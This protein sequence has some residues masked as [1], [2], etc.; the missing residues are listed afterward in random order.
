VHRL[1]QHTDSAQLNKNLLL[2][3]GA[4]IDTKPELLID[5]DDVKCKHGATV[6]Q[7]SDE[8]I[9]Y[10]Q[11]RAVSREAAT[12]MLIHGFAGD[13]LGEIGHAGIRERLIRI[14]EESFFGMSG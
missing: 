2:S 5:A 13:V 12:R 3:P 4:R 6:G 14:L 7:L 9:F 11:S 10:L 8:E 1:A